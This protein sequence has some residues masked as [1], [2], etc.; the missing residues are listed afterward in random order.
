[1]TPANSNP[2]ANATDAEA[3]APVRESHLRSLL[4]GL[5]W[6]LVAT[7]TTVLIAYWI[8]D[9]VKLALE[10][11]AVEVVA[12]IFV[13]YLHERAWQLVPERAPR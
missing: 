8:L 1:M 3:P 12:K 11:G 13:Y 6:R 2:D 10:I 5:T 9:D 4:K 7:G